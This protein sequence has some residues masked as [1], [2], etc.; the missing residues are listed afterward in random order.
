M[1]KDVK[2]KKPPIRVKR[3]FKFEIR[4]VFPITDPQAFKDLTLLDDKL[5]DREGEAPLF[6]KGWW[7]I[8]YVGDVQVGFCGLAQSK[9]RKTLGYM[10]RSGVLKPYRGCGLQRLFI[11]TRIQRAKDLGFKG[12]T[13]ATYNNPYS[14]NNLIDAGFRL[15]EPDRKWLCHGAAYWKKDL[16]NGST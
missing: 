11:Q 5:F 7:W 14:G 6:L 2:V 3:D 8:A 12:M 10:T 4:E 9:Q 13:V 16:E 15:Y 1:R